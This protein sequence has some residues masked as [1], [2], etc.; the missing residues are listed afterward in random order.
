LPTSRGA[1]QDVE[2]HHV[3]P[4]L[5]VDQLAIIMVEVSALR[6]DAH[7]ISRLSTWVV[8]TVLRVHVEPTLSVRVFRGTGLNRRK[9]ASLWL[10]H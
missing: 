6:T 2:L 9:L 3:L 7:G 5:L 1:E 10:F 8:H 4:F